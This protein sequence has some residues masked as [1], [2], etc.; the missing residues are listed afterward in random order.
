MQLSLDR[1]NR[2]AFV[3]M[4]DRKSYFFGFVIYLV[5]MTSVR[6]Q[7]KLSE[8]ENLDSVINAISTPIYKLEYFKA[9]ENIAK[10]RPQGAARLGGA[11]RRGA[12][13]YPGARPQ[14]RDLAAGRDHRDGPARDRQGSR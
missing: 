9:N 3:A 10:Q 2:R 7:M 14:G 11:A 5:F 6:G 8:I 12:R 1:R 4:S 13:A